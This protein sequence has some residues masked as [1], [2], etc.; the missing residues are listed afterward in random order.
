MKTREDK[1]MSMKSRDNLLAFRD[2]SSE[3][4]YKLSLLLKLTENVK[5]PQ[6]INIK[7]MGYPTMWEVDEG[8]QEVPLQGSWARRWLL[9]HRLHQLC[10]QLVL[11]PY[12]RLFRHQGSI[13]HIHKV[14]II[15][16]LNYFRKQVTKIISTHI[17]P[18]TAECHIYFTF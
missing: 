16:P 7:A 8:L 17:V 13:V 14:S 5:W 3:M 9:R 6:T 10:Q 4:E 1:F 2:R 11:F 15:I 18:D 12:A